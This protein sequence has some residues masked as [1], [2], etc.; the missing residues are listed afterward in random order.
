MQICE[1]IRQ[2]RVSANLTQQEI[3][4]KIGV[5]RS[6]YAEWERRIEPDMKTLTKISE[7]TNTP[8]SI[9]ISQPADIK[10]VTSFTDSKKG[11]GSLLV[12]EASITLQVRAEARQETILAALAEVLANQ[13]ETH[14]A[15]E[16]KRLEADVMETEA[17]LRKKY[18]LPSVF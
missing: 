6:T 13:R 7:L 15:E 3:A 18:G 4:D 9:L 8:I 2:A 1:N 16:L 5:K 17:T 10:D 11:G 14:P 12:G